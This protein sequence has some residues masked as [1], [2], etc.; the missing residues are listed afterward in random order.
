MDGRDQAEGTSD[1]PGTS[2][3]WCP[4]WGCGLRRSG[5]VPDG[6]EVEP[7]GV[8]ASQLWDGEKERQGSCLQ[9]WRLS[10]LD[11]PPGS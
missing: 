2:Q 8:R 3:K 6:S 7:W 10:G 1:G 4:R 11:V 5:Q 9:R